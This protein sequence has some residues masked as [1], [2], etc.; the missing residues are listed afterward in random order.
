MGT[1]APAPA[2]SESDITFLAGADLS[3]LQFQPVKHSAAADQTVIAVAA[4]GDDCIGILQNKPVSGGAASVRTSGLSKVVADAGITRGDR[5]MWGSANKVLLW[6]TAA[7]K[8]MIGFALESA[9]ADGE[10]ITAMIAIDNN[11][12]SA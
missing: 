5:L 4:V 12:V 2:F 7:E 9:G 11:L 6:T 8:T 1:T 10:V 3:A